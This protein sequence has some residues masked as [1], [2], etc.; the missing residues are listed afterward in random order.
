LNREF[1]DEEVELQKQINALVVEISEKDPC[2][3]TE[4]VAK[5]KQVEEPGRQLPDPSLR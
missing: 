5:L 2:N 3:T 4:I 1:S